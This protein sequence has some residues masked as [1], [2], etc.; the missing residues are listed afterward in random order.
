MVSIILP[1]YNVERYLGTCI[2]SVLR[3]TISDWELV[4]VDDCSSDRT[5]EIANRYVATDKRIKLVRLEHNSGPAH[6]RNVGIENSRGEYLA[7]IDSDDTI[8]S[9]YIE[10]LISNANRYNSDIT[11]CQYRQVS[12]N[13]VGMKQVYIVE[14]K[15]SKGKIFNRAEAVALIF[16]RVPGFGSMWNKLYRRS[17][18]ID[19]K[20]RLN[21]F[22]HR[23]EDWE[24]NIECFRQLDSM[25]AIDEAPYNYIRRE[26]SIM[27][28]FRKKDF[29]LMCR[30]VRLL[31]CIERENDLSVPQGA[32]A[33]EFLPSMVEYAASAC[34]KSSNGLDMIRHISASPE[35]QFV[36]SDDK[37][38]RILPISYTIISYLMLKGHPMVAYT[39]GKLL[40]FVR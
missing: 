31:Q 26:A 15:L 27:G 8:E 23:A 21:E 9:N 32:Y 16:Q 36:A 6:A 10:V 17:L 11:W 12:A 35:Y 5:I 34:K 24:F 4:L 18:I 13:A 38:R 14:N 30:S 1:L 3:Q 33:R 19:K 28:T 29:D 39:F 2:D 40:K 22:R 20:I 37:I 7:F 25:V